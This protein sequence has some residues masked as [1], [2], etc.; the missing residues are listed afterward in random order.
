MRQFTAV[1]LALAVGGILSGLPEKT[2]TRIS[3]DSRTISHHKQTVFF[4]LKGR[5]RDGHIFIQELVHKGLDLFIVHHSFD[6]NYYPKDITFIKVE[7]TL[8][9]LQKFAAFIRSSYHG[10]VIAITG[11]NGKTIVKEWL[12][13]V[14]KDTK[15][16]FRSPLSYNSQVGVPLSVFFLED[17]YDIAIIE[18]GISL[19]GEMIKLERIIKPEIGIITNLGEAHQQNFK[20]PAEKLS[21]KLLLFRNAKN[22]IYC[23]DH[24]NIHNNIITIL[25][26]SV[27][28]ISWGNDPDCD[29]Q[30]TTRTR[31]SNGTIISIK[32]LDQTVLIPFFDNASVENALHVLVLSLVINNNKENIIKSFDRLEQ[33][34]MRLEILKGI[35]SCTL[36][37]DTYNSDVQSIKNSLELLI[38]Q[39]QHKTKI[40]ILSDIFQSGRTDSDLYF[41][42]A[43]LVN[44]LGIDKFIG[45]GQSI[46]QYANYFNQGPLFFKDT[47]SFL[48]SGIWSDF[49]NAAILIKGSRSFE[50]ENITNVLQ[51]KKNQT[52]LE[53][54]LSSLISNLNV[55]KSLLNP[56]AKVMAMVKA[57]SYGSG[58]YEIAN[59]L[60][61]HKIDYLAV[62]YVDEGVEL[63]RNGINLP[64]MVMNP[65]PSSFYTIVDY[66]L[67]PELYSKVI[68]EKFIN[69]ADKNGLKSYPVHIELDTG[70]HRL[71][72]DSVSLKE[73][74]KLIP[75]DFI[76]I[77]SV[78]S[79]LAAA[80]DPDHD[81]FTKRQISD[82]IKMCKLIR[83]K[84]G[85]DFMMHIL[86]SA[87][88]VRFPEAQ[89]DMVRLGIGLYGVNITG[90][91]ELKEISTFKTYISQLRPIKGND[92]IGYG[93][94][95][96][97]KGN[98][99]VAVIPAGYADG[100]PYSLSKG[101]G[102][103][104]IKNKMA[105]LI[106]KV[107]MDMC[108]IDVTGMDVYEGD[109]VIIFG[110]EASV[111]DLAK[112][113]GTIPYEIL[114]GIPARV[115]RVYLQE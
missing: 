57:F 114:S 7:D 81:D 54:N 40:I 115:K 104:L 52:K 111:K 30:I 103:F 35:N 93:R 10:T 82:Y 4:A 100:I 99:K 44:E 28:K 21:E 12:Y 76:E 18:A 13:Q 63:R 98:G 8:E 2:F 31:I 71:G 107:C 108:M 97:M 39:N 87:G 17:F 73:L 45:I 109:E 51:E 22:V 60:Q 65:D 83:Q 43:Q 20:T 59:K 3:I 34:E 66:K 78:F 47:A 79:H 67:E 77:I 106:G 53:I 70:M 41:E 9:A 80:E 24:E 92:T 90:L 55:Y 102:R 69:F 64:V 88:T 95:G 33:I 113:A 112:K 14:L 105:P 42:I 48:R 89:F 75:S 15:T 49:N 110:P 58:S 38:Q 37:S 101:S 62:A 16:V 32:G 5:N 74:L 50:F 19:P 46:C 27:K 72:F 26:E 6:I 96:K 86:N 91:S 94:Y 61:F 56:S 11:S 1:E 25:P 36:I 29:Y 84:Y 68:L 23:R 85:K